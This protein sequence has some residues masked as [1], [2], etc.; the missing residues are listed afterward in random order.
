MQKG[1]LL[2]IIILNQPESGCNDWQRQIR[3]S[4]EMGHM[5]SYIVKLL[6]NVCPNLPT[7]IDVTVTM[8]H[9]SKKY[10]HTNNLYLFKV[11]FDQT[12]NS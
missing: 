3:M 8:S 9:P 12:K 11:I 4:N 6:A 2:Q 5:L 7:S 1:S 10:V